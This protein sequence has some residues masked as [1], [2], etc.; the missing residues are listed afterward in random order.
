MH[1]ITLGILWGE[2]YNG[3]R[4][5]TDLFVTLKY[6]T[7]FLTL[8][9]ENNCCIFLLTKSSLYLLHFFPSTFTP[10]THGD[11]ILSIAIYPKGEFREPPPSTLII[12]TSAYELF[13]NL[14]TLVQKPS[15]SRL[16][17]ENPYHHLL[18]FE[19][20]C[21]MFAIADMTQDTLKWKLFPFSLV[22]K[23]EQW[24]MYAVGSV[25][26]NWDELRDNFCLEFFLLSHIITLHRDIHYF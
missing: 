10:A 23:A 1:S 20:L 18:D 2:S 14:M 17:S 21:S 12:L 19:R 3:I 22:G 13:P 15:F 16:E 11:A 5:L 25:N 6:P 9:P 4:A 26:D 8:L 24:Y 7:S